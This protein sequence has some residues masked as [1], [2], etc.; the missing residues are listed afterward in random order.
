MQVLSLVLKK[1]TFLKRYRWY[2]TRLNNQIITAWS[3][4]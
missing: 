1:L 4:R 2:H 3:A